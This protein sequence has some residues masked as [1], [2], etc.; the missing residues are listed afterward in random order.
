MRNPTLLPAAR[1]DEVYVGVPDE[2][3]ES[4]LT[5]VG[6]L[7]RR[8]DGWTTED[9]GSASVGDP[10]VVHYV[11]EGDVMMQLTEVISVVGEDERLTMVLEHRGDPEV[12]ET[13]SEYR[14]KVPPG[15][16]LAS[17]GEEADLDVLDVS[18]N[19]F[20][21]RARTVYFLDDLV[22]VRL[23]YEHLD[24]RGMVRIRSI[25]R[26]TAPFRYGMTVEP[27]ST[28]LAAALP[29]LRMALQRAYASGLLDL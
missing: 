25:V 28:R 16:V 6:V 19:G 4:T 12:V 9:F 5:P 17:L 14:V 10:L 13:R 8:D 18:L 3:G 24:L 29:L 27:S 22:P 26:S 7:S 21:V 20:S 2:D 1:R 15:R 23:A 11:D